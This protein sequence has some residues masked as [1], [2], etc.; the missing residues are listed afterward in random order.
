[1]KKICLL[2]SLLA[3]CTLSHSQILVS[4]G[5]IHSTNVQKWIIF[6]KEIDYLKTTRTYFMFPDV[7][8][9][10]LGY[11]TE[12]LKK[13]WDFTPIEAITVSTAKEMK[14]KGVSVFSFS[15]N[16]EEGLYCVAVGLYTICR[17]GDNLSKNG[18]NGMVGYFIVTPRM[19]H[20]KDM[21][22]MAQLPEKEDELNKY[23]CEKAVYYNFRIGH[24]CKYLALLN[25][26]F[27]D[28]SKQQV[29]APGIIAPTDPAGL[30]A[31]KSETLYIPNHV[32][33]Q[34]K[35]NIL[36]QKVTGERTTAEEL[37]KD[38]PYRYEFVPVET[39]DEMLLDPEQNI[40]YLDLLGTLRLSYMLV[41]RSKTPDVLYSISMSDPYITS[42]E[43]KQLGKSIK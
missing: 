42:K 37:M 29:N 23:V 18:C 39:L 15:V 11:F 27:K 35:F 26:N 31:L 17:E 4:H 16:V 6:Q 7:E 22:I 14:E 30:S 24:I 43:I 12:E 33:L 5:L 38:Y 34:E 20:L 19:E 8:A 1:M 40:C 2:V 21:V 9:D 10:N 36:T 25:R 3:M 41:L 13:V 28:I 32:L